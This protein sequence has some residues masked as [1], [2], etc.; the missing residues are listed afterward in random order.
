VK[1]LDRGHIAPVARH[2]PFQRGGGRSRRGEQRFNKAPGLGGVELNLVALINN[3][4]GHFTR[5]QGDEFGERAALNGGG[6]LEKL[7]VR[8]GYP[9]DEALAFRFFQCR[10]HAPNV[11]LRGTQIKN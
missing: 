2:R 4:A 6:F 11:C 10:R 9:G 3:L 8:R 7:L 1:F 5:V